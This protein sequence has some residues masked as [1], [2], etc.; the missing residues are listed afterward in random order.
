MKQ[1]YKFLN[2][3]TM[4]VV[5]E[6]YAKNATLPQYMSKMVTARS[7][8]NNTVM[9]KIFHHVNDGT[10]CQC[11]MCKPRELSRVANTIQHDWNPVW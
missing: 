6:A 8:F 9:V 11:Y 4:E 7:S 3:Y 2:G 1:N 5:D 10:E